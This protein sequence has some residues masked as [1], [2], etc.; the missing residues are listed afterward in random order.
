MKKFSFKKLLTCILFSV[1]VTCFIGSTISFIENV[2]MN[3]YVTAWNELENS[4]EF[5]ED[6][7]NN[8]DGLYDVYNAF[9]DGVEDLKE[10]YGEDY[11]AESVLLNKLMMASNREEEIYTYLISVIVGIGLG[12]IVYIIN[13]QKANGRVFVIELVL[14]VGVMGII[15]LAIDYIYKFIV[16]SL[17]KTAG[18]N[19]IFEDTALGENFKVFILGAFV[20]LIVIVYL[21]NLIVQ[22]INSKRLNE[23]LNRK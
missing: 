17:I 14:A 13:E 1:M 18:Y 5:I 4:E 20:T 3:S 9:Q 19:L 6:T 11:P 10:K 21:V 8:Y 7:K 15:L 16:N 2:S 22:K 12:T 23:E